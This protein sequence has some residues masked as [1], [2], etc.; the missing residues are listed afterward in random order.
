MSRG[1]KVWPRHHFALLPPSTPNQQLSIDDNRIRIQEE[2]M[3]FMATSGKM[4]KGKGGPCSGDSKA[5]SGGN[6]G[7]PSAEDHRLVSNGEQAQS[8]VSPYLA[9]RSLCCH[10]TSSGRPER[11]W[12]YLLFLQHLNAE[13][14]HFTVLET[15]HT[16]HDE[17]RKSPV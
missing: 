11:R 6:M 1:N 2:L 7:R 14:Q 8:Q 17:A 3:V 13:E 4:G 15:Y 10:S 12:P 5:A 16:I 9:E